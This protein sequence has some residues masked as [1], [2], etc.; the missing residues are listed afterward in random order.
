[1]GNLAAPVVLNLV[2]EL[3]LFG[4][5]LRF[6]RITIVGLM[7]LSFLGACYSLY[8]Y[9][10]VQHGKNHSSVRSFTDIIG[11]EHLILLIHFYP[12]GLLILRRDV[13]MF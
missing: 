11:R 1:M 9:S 12:L 2:G 3:T 4:G 7:L 6:S 10:C 5:L 8:L 13:F